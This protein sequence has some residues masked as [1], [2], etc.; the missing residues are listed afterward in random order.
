M[1]AKGI[2]NKMAFEADNRGAALVRSLVADAVRRPCCIVWLAHPAPCQ[3]AAVI[4]FAISPVAR[5]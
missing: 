2:H 4:V 3:P 1:G 5:C